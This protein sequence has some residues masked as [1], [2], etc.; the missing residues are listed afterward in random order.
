MGASDENLYARPCGGHYPA[1]VTAPGW[2][3]P[4]PA[5]IPDLLKDIIMPRFDP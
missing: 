4:G 1:R 2:G 5:R 3:E